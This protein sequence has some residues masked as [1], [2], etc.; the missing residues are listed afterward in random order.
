MQA[1]T[2]QHNGSCSREEPLPA[3]EQR[4]LFCVKFARARLPQPGFKQPHA[5]AGAPQFVSEVPLPQVPL[6]KLCLPGA[7]VNIET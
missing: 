1:L 5:A 3:R 4:L 2:L 6:L 7:V